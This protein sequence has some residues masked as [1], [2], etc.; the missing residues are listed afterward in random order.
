MRIGGAIVGG[1]L[2]GFVGAMIWAGISY[3]TGFE[4]GWIAWGVGGMVGLGCVWG[5]KG[6]GN[7]L[8]LTAVVIT[9]LSILA[10]KYAAVEFSIRNEIG[11]EEEVLHNALA[12][13]QDDEVVVSYLADEIIA[14]Q[15]ARGDTITWPT[16]V[17]PEEAIRQQDYPPDI[18]SK[19]ASKWKE[20]SPEDQENYR[21]QLADQIRANVQAFMGDVSSYGFLH[22]FGFMDLLFFGLAVTTAFKIAAGGSAHDTESDVDTAQT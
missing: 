3:F 19:A 6:S 9:L 15:E 1:A 21:E 5:S 17:N 4:I 11:T 16:G 7:L 13:L 2:A 20:M 18:W 8:G 10:G 22:S 14:E 12:G